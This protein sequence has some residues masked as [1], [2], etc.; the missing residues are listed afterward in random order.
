MGNWQRLARIHSDKAA[1]VNSGAVITAVGG[2]IVS[3]CTVLVGLLVRKSDR[4]AKMT[5]RYFDDSEFN[6]DMVN[7]IRIDYWQLFGWANIVTT[8][9]HVLLD[10]LPHVCAGAEAEVKALMRDIGELPKM[11]EP[12]HLRIERNR[13]AQRDQEDKEK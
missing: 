13:K 8:K 3:V 12:N 9:W 5:Q 4:N 11:P 2:V 6:I 1:L 10:G 7:A